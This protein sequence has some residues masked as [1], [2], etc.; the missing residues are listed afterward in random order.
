MPPA[1]SGEGEM[2]PVDK[3]RIPWRHALLA[4]PLALAAGCTE[5][6]F[7]PGGDWRRV[8]F[9][10]AMNG[11]P[12]GHVAGYDNRCARSGRTPDAEAW[13]LGYQDGL[14]VYCT[15][16]HA[17]QLGRYRGYFNPG[18]CPEQDRKRLRDANHHGMVYRE[19]LE[20]MWEDS[21]RGRF[22]PRF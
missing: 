19:M 6:V 3:T 15:E 16:R 13:R 7:C 2:T 14:A 8:G 4:L 12:A 9:N 5:P 20:D 1:V 11:R 10:D 17:Y 22:I 18:I 21:L